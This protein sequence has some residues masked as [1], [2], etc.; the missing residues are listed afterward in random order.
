MSKSRP[1]TVV[2]PDE[3]VARH[4]VDA[5]RAHVLFLAPFE[6]DITWDETTI[7]GVVRWLDR[8]AGL[9][10]GGTVQDATAQADDELRRSLHRTIKKVSQDVEAFKFNTAIAALMSF[11][12]EMVQAQGKVDPAVWAEGCDALVRLLAPLVPDLSQRLWQQMGRSGSVDQQAWPQWDEALAAPV[13]ITLVVQ[14]NGHTRARIPAAAGLS[15]QDLTDLAL[16]TQVAQDC[17]NGGP[18]RRVIVVPDR[19]VNIVV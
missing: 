9:V 18:P 16:A 6:A 10:T 17:L 4:G 8:V 3:V 19:L 5:L 7:S 1:D 15:D 2:T 14:V 11:S 12:D 13:A